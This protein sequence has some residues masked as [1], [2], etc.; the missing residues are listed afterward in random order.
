[1][2]GKCIA[3]Q[4]K[5]TFFNIS[6]ASLTS[7]WF[8]E[9]E[10]TIRA[11][12]AVAKAHQPSVI[13]IDEIDSLLRTR[14]SDESDATRRSKTELLAQIV[15]FFSNFFEFFFTKMMFFRMECGAKKMTKFW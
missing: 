2:L 6:A 14:G 15:S 13:F 3:S 8:G 4:C 7:M 10:K 5:S 12:F 9:T 1:M 11:L